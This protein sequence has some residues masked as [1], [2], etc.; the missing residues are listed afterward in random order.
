[1]P[2]KA[3]GAGRRETNAAIWVLIV[4]V[5]GVAAG[6]GL[7]LTVHVPSAPSPRPVPPGAPAPLTPPAPSTAVTQEYV[8]LSTVCLALLIALLV[9]YARTYRATRAPYVL[10]LVFFLLALAIATVLDSPLLY[11]AFGLGPG[12]LGPFLA[13]GELLL[14]AA[15]SVFLYLS[16]Q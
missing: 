11:T 14:A 8:V 12:N 15:L 16:L 5:V 2:T 1:M 3:T 6:I 7:A 9:V 4:L 13:L 10:G